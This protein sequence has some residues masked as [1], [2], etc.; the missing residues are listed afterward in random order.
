[1]MLLTSCFNKVKD[2][3]S[4]VESQ[5]PWTF[6]LRL[7][8]ILLLLPTAVFSQAPEVTGMVLVPAGEFWM[9]RTHLSL[10]D[11]LGWV[12]RARMDDRP[13]HLVSIDSFY[14]DKYE[15]TNAGYTRFIEATGNRKPHHWIHGKYPEGKAEHPVYNVSWDEAAAYCKWVSQR[16]PT[17]AEWEWAARGGLDRKL[18]AW[19]DEHPRARGGRLGYQ[20]AGA[21]ERAVIGRVGTSIVGSFPPNGFGLYDMIGNVWEWVADWYAPNYYSISP[22]RNPPGPDSGNYR[23]IRG[24]G[25][26]DAD[27]RFLRVYYRN[28]T[29]SSARFNTIGFRCAKSVLSEGA[30]APD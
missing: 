5:R 27:D 23:V 25:W 15:V 24:G 12:E 22:D 19:G 18:Y 10:P 1:M 4:K 20:A 7:L 21:V 29:D 11:E 17:E 28:F 14:M 9:G 3:R 2:R 16:L 30:K 6:D 8:T 26:P 13:V